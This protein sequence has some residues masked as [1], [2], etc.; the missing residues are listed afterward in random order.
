MKKT[1]IIFLVLFASQNIFA[2]T[3]WVA[4]N[5][6]SY[7]PP[8]R[9]MMFLNSVTGFACGNAGNILKTTNSG[10]NWFGIGSGIDF[11]AGDVFFINENTGWA[12]GWF[13]K[14]I[15]TTN[16]GSS[17]Q[18]LLS[19][20]NTTTINC[21]YFINNNTGFA[22][23]QSGKLSK[24]TD[25]GL[26]WRVD[27]IYDFSITKIK[28]FNSSTG[29]AA[30]NY[31]SIFVT[32]NTGETWVERVITPD[33]SQIYS[34]AFINAQT[35]YIA[36]YSKIWKTNDGG[37]SW[38]LSH[39]VISQRGVS[40][41]SFLNEQTGFISGFDGTILKTQNAG[42]NWSNLQSNVTAI[43]QLL[44]VDSD[45]CFFI[46]DNLKIYRSLNG[47]SNWQT[48]SA[49]ITQS[50]L[51]EIK[52]FDENTGYI[53]GDEGTFLKTTNSGEQWS[54]LSIPTNNSLRSMFF[55]NQQTGWV[56]GDEGT[57]FKTTDGCMTW[58][59][60]IRA[61]PG[62]DFKSIVFINSLTGFILSGNGKLFKST[63]SGEN[64]MRQT[65]PPMFQY[66]KMH[67]INETTGFITGYTGYD[68]VLRTTDAGVTWSNSI[69]SIATNS[70]MHFINENTGFG[71]GYYRL[72]KTTDAGLSW[73]MINYNQNRFFYAVQFV[74]SLTGYASGSNGMIYK[75]T[76]CGENWTDISVPYLSS[77]NKVYFVNEL[78]GWMIGSYGSIFKTTTGGVLTGF[79][80]ANSEIPV[81]YSLHQ[82]Y[83]NPFNPS[84]KIKYEI[85]FS[86]FV[87]LKVF[88]LLGKE[89][90]SL[91]NEKQ[92]AGSYAV[93]FNS[94]E[95]NLPSGVY[96]YI[97]N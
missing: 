88:D 20:G 94:T 73:R 2:Q 41:I 23:L 1:I 89:V 92:N 76:N 8:V 54:I 25:G 74:N 13:G 18:T 61:F 69:S 16:G 34:S 32:T 59:V 66:M 36:T 10:S 63:D 91:V 77:A 83:P 26:N 19:I 49:S 48:Y 29:I 30:T 42:V 11:I 62:S 40:S 7:H 64:W 43:I 45:K 15:R 47:G 87:A 60:P 44:T 57:Y 78:T 39:Q 9:N 3:A 4:Q 97:L 67:F 24:S 96:F 56:C 27:S 82:N 72:S 84:T 95:F 17:W 75:S 14:L 12:C 70:S 53:I 79:T 55:I 35:G 71:A 6:A 93:D 65:I 33:Q 90:A 5:P 80:Q 50:S 21:V 85:K 51:T 46:S 22:G 86:G 37:I 58:Q 52:F 68:F 38:Q 31:G 28:F 81:K